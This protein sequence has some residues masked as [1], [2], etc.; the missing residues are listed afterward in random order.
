[1]Q[2]GVQQQVDMLSGMTYVITGSIGVICNFTI[3]ED[4]LLSFY[5][6]GN[7]KMIKGLLDGLK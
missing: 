1:M 7:P 6:K 5:R 4:A 2:N 3:L